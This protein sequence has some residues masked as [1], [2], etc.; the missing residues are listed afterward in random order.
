[1]K[2]N[3]RDYL[4]QMGAGAAGFLAA[5]ELPV[6]GRTRAGR[7]PTE[8]RWP[9][10][11]TPPV[12][13]A[14]VTAIYCG[15]A[16]FTYHNDRYV[17]VLFNR[18]KGG[19]R[20]VVQIYKDPDY[21]RRCPLAR[22]FRPGPTERLKLAVPGQSAGNPEV[23]QVDSHPFDRNRDNSTYAEDFRWLPD[24]H[25]DDFYPDGYPLKR[26]RGTRL[27]VHTG[28][29]YTRVRSKSTFK[30]I[31][32]ADP[33]CDDEVRDFGYIALYMATAISAQSNVVLYRNGSPYYTF[34]TGNKYQ[35][36]FRNECESS[37]L[38]PRLQYNHCD[39]T[40]RNHFHFS[41][42]LLDI[43][44]RK[45]KYGLQMKRPCRGDC[46]VPDFCIET[47]RPDKLSDEAPCSGAGYGKAPGFP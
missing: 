19:H 23:F 30:L 13:D 8:L 11:P 38:C 35:I 12:R 10:T 5:A 17:D 18:G 4:L 41:R 24:L 36:I 3:R 45:P 14:F 7:V 33:E 32:K 16:N 37:S 34:E 39:E 29:F 42:D 20:L 40:R 21:P 9:I 15:L 22:K 46:A 26:G 6:F 44:S 27:A 47:H 1:M 2:I 28:T 43:P 31:D 25:S